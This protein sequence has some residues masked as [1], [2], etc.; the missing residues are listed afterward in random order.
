MKEKIQFK[1][2]DKP[3]ELEIDGNHSL[4]WVLRTECAMTGPKFG[5][6][7]GFCGACTVLVNMKP[8]RSCG[9][10]VSFVKDTEVI[11]IDPSDAAEL[12]FM[13][14]LGVDP[15]TPQADAG[16]RME[17]PPSLAW[18]IGTSPAATAEA[19]PPLDPPGEWERSQGLAVGP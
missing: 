16:M 10:P 14:S 19:D 11:T 9:F 7:N 1:L 4:L 8:I 12:G 5:C 3:I 15:K 2:N 18:A 6:G 17:P 13:R